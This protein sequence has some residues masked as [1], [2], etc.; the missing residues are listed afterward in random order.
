MS[1]EKAKAFLETFGLAE[2]IILKEESTATVPEAARALGV[3]ND[4]IAKTLSFRKD[5]SAM[6]IVMSGE[7]R[8]DN[9]KF[10]GTFG[11]KARMLDASE[12]ETLL[13]QKVGGVCPFGVTV[14]IYL[15]QSL[16]SHE[17]VFP[18]TGNDHSA[19]ELTPDELEHITK[20][21][22]VDISKI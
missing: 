14:P 15:D 12:V 17:T 21:V 13:E 9:K 4:R 2:R 8:I 16:K 19:I 10:K 20:G 3:E 18:A 7:S 11:F 5:D 6:L 1:L 22:W